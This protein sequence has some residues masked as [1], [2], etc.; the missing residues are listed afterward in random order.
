[1]SSGK[2]NDG[3]REIWGFLKDPFH[4]NRSRSPSLT[5]SPSP[6][7]SPTARPALSN[8]STPVPDTTSPTNVISGSGTVT[9]NGITSTWPTDAR[10]QSQNPQSPTISMPVR[11][12]AFQKA[13]QE[14]I[15]N[16][17]DDDKVAFHSATDVMEKIEEMQKSK[18]RITPTQVQKMKKALQCV[19]QFLGSVIICIQHSPEISTLVV[20]GLN[21]ILTVSTYESSSFLALIY[22]WYLYL[23]TLD[24][25]C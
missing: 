25:L 10:D 22:N 7:P 8:T 24:S 17:S 1:M 5:P 19:K 6:S 14:Y 13:I 11:N 3:V 4:R 16:L 21:C 12:E 15:N 20:G 23:F 2:K 9:D 18:S